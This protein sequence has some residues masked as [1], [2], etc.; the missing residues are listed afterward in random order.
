MTHGLTHRITELLDA[1]T[2][3]GGYPAAFVCT[4]DGLVIAAAGDA[5]LAELTAAVVSLF[6]DVLLR[7][8]RDLKFSEVDEVTLVDPRTGRL[9]V[10]PLPMASGANFFLVVQV[11]RGATWRRHTNALRRQLIPVLAPLAQGEVEL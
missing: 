10:R 5:A 1:R 11:P 2:A 9:V 6:D 8:T 4:D 3:E 7:A